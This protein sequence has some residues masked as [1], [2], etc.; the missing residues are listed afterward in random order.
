MVKILNLY[1]DII[2]PVYGDYTSFYKEDLLITFIWR[3]F[4]NYLHTCTKISYGKF[5]VWPSL[6][7]N[8]RAQD[9]IYFIDKKKE[10]T[11]V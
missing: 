5:V 3:R 2:F 8:E 10:S 1:I 4:I 7:L 9:C 6:L 11:V